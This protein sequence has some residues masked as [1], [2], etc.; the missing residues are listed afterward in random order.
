LRSTV[1]HCIDA[2]GTA[3]R[4][5]RDLS[6]LDDRQRERLAQSPRSL[7]RRAEPGFCAQAKLTRKERKQAS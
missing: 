3:S 7:F 2:L 4:V 6:L 1:T 5:E